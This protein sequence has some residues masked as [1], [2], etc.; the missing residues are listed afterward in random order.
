MCGFCSDAWVLVLLETK[1]YIPLSELGPDHGSWGMQDAG[2]GKL[3]IFDKPKQHKA[4]AEAGSFGNYLF[5]TYGIK[6]IKLLQRLSQDKDRPWQD[7]F[8]TD[9][10]ELEANWLKQ[11]QTNG[12]TSAENVSIILKLFERD[13]GTACSEAQQLVP[14][15]P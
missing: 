11:L 2:G 8:G 6:K 3:S 5:E 14:V 10:P 13:P 4:Y 9:L 7:V 15:K 12:K 1:S